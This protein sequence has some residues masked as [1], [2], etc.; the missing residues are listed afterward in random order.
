[1]IDD[2][3]LRALRAS[4][5]PDGYDVEVTETPDRVAVRILAGEDAC[6][7]CLSPEPVMKGIVADLLGVP[8]ERITL[9]Y[10]SPGGAFPP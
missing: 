6:A 1:M 9:T 8:A 10:P 3:G 5:R 7:D 4:L 2:A